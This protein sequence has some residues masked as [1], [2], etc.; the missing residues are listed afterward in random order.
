MYVEEATSILLKNGFT[1]KEAE[2]CRKAIAKRRPYSQYKDKFSGS[3]TT[4]SQIVGTFTK[5]IW[6][7]HRYSITAV[8]GPLKAVSSRANRDIGFY[9]HKQEE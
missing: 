3:Q 9:L 5:N 1:L 2:E 4:W 6:S 8:R 7:V